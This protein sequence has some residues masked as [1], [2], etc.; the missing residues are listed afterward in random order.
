MAGVGAHLGRHPGFDCETAAKDART[1][2][3]DIVVCPSRFVVDSL[4]AGVRASKRIVLAPFGSPEPATDEKSGT[5]PNRG[6]RSNAGAIRGWHD[7]AKGLADLF[8]AMKL[9]HRN[10]V[11]LVIMGTEIAKT[12]FYRRE[13][14]GFIHEKPRPHHAVLALMQTCDVFCLP[15]IVEGRAPVVIQEAMSRGLPAIVTPNSGADDVVQ[16]GVNGFVVANPQ[17]RGNCG[18]AV[19]V[20]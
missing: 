12:D 1:R 5:G 4:P 13:F 10:D 11:E 14:P 6:P 15:S 16:E 20:C 8:A 19:L 3:A 9:M 17:P 18:K 7:P 2:V